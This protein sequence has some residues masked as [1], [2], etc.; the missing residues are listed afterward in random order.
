MFWYIDI[1][2]IDLKKNK[3]FIIGRILERE[4]LYD[5]LRLLKH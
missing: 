1:N 5:F 4:N 2:S 3:R